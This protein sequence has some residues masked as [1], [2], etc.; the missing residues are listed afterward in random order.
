MSLAQRTALIRQVR[1][2][3]PATTLMLAALAATGVS[4]CRSLGGYSS[5]AITPTTS[6]AR[7]APVAPAVPTPTPSLA[8]IVDHQLQPGHYA[9][10]EQALRQY[11]EQHPQDRA[12]RGLLHQLTADPER[13]LGSRSRAHVVQSGES[14]STLAARYLGDANLF[15]I[16]ARYN[17]ST[18]PS[19]LR[20]GQTLRIPL[21]ARGASPAAGAAASSAAPAGPAVAESSVAKARRL[22]DES[23]SLFDQGHAQQALARMDEALRL[24]PRLQPAGAEAASLR[25]RLLDSYHEQ[26]VV[27]YRDQQLDKAIALWNRVLAIAPN[28]EPAVAYR[29]RALELKQRLKQ[30]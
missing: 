22:Q 7:P 9:E 3:W 18:N 12:A 28:Y 4:G 5:V 19:L 24:D 13:W 26:A 1:L 27:L 29:A 16:L 14:Y 23:V 25:S 10:G 6:A 15:L 30:Y 21:S 20:T 17:H 2:P 8:S 11:V